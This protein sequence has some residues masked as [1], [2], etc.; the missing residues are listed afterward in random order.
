MLLNGDA[1]Y[2]TRDIF[3][4]PVAYFCQSVAGSAEYSREPPGPY[5]Y[6]IKA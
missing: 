6:S 1:C 5:L 3:L 4:A 2:L